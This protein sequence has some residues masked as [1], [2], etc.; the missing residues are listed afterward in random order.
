MANALNKQTLEDGPRNAVV[1]IDLEND[2]SDTAETVIVDPATLSATFPISNQLRV[3]EIQYSIQDGWYVELF[4]KAT[5]SKVMVTLAGRGM[6]P[7]GPNYGGLQN[8]ATAPG[9]VGQISLSTTG[10]SSGT[11][12]ATLILHMVK[13]TKP[14]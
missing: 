4:W 13:Q 12:V 8:N 11:M 2:T 7:V 14:S 10:Y 3:D 6:F 1:K 9:N 5:T